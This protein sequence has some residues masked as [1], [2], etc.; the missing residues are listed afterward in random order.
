MW[1]TTVKSPTKSLYIAFI[2]LFV[3]QDFKLKDMKV[4]YG[5]YFLMIPEKRGADTD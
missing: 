5:I 4:E 1:L 2:S 3:F